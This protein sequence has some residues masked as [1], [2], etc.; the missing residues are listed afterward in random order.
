MVRQL[1]KLMKT[2][3]ALSLGFLVEQRSEGSENL[4]L[5]MVLSF[6]TAR[7]RHSHS[8]IQREQY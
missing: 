5:K 1:L 2:R 4:T 6:V 7:F 8:I 3:N